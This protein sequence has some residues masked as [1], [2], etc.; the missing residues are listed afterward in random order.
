MPV[1]TEDIVLKALSLVNDPE[2]H[3]DLVSLGMVER[4][5]VTGTQVHAKINLTTPA[6]PLKGVIEADVRRAIEA[7]GASSVTVEFGATV[8]ASNKPALPGIQ[9]VILVGSGK[10][11]VGKSSVS[12]NLAIALAQSGAR[13]G[14]MDAD[15]YGPSIAHMLGNTEDRIKANQNKQMLPLERFGVKF[16]SMANLVPAGQALVWR[17]PMLHGAIQQFLKEALWGELDYLII[18]L[19]PGTGDVQLSLAQSVSITGA[20][21]VTTP[22]DVALIDAA[23]AMDMFKKSSIPI[24]GVVENMSYFVAP[25][26]GTRYD[27]FGHGGG[28]RKAEQMSLHFLGEVPL[29]MPLREASDQGTPVVISHPESS[30]AQSLVKISQNLAGRISVQSLQ[31]LPML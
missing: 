26:T 10:G 29:D 1:V 5:V 12:T 30:S 21:I 25:D 9:H 8:R 17:G 19:P 13:V 18:D 4:V 23:R 2:L 16:L 3:Q 15:I 14:L 28:K 20:V 31:S 7:V 27:I 11:G 6:C 22:Q 24:L